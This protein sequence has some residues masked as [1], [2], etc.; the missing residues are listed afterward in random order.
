M[1]YYYKNYCS[2]SYAKMTNVKTG[3]LVNSNNIPKSEYSHGLW[4][5]DKVYED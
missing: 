3:E 5:V 1:A 2:D 4:T